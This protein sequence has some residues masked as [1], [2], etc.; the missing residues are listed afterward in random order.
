MSQKV[1]QYP[2]LAQNI[3][4]CI[5][6]WQITVL[7]SRLLS[8]TQNKRAGTKSKQLSTLFTPSKPQSWFPTENITLK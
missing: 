8:P 4:L 2:Q 6:N 5:E 3:L 7:S 1:L